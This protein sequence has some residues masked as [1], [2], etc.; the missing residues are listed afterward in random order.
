M[1][2]DPAER[3]VRQLRGRDAEPATVAPNDAEP[4]RGAELGRVAG[5]EGDGS[6]GP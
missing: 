6:A 4:L 5:L 3:A 2:V 1:A